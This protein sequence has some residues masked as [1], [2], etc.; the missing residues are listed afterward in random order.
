MTRA[1]LRKELATLWASPVPWVAGAVLQAVLALLFV[2]QLQG[3]SQAVVQPLFPIAGLLVVVT[4]PVLAMRTFAE[5]KRTGNLDVLLAMPVSAVPLAVGKWAGAWLTA[6]AIL[7]PSIV[8]A[9]LTALWGSPDPGPIVSG[10]VGVALLAAAVAAIGVLASAAT[11]SQALAALVTILTG[12]VLWFVGS[13][14]GGSTTTRVL[15]SVSLSERLRTF[16]SGGIDSGDL[17]FFIG[18]AMVCTL[19][20]AFVIRPRPVVGGV[21][22]AALLVTV[23]GAGTHQLTDLTEQKSLTLSGI[24]RDVVSAV[25]DDVTIT[26]F[27]G[28]E[29]AG[30]VETVTLL[31]RYARLSQH[32]DT[33]VVDPSDKPGDVRRFGINPVLGGVV[34]QRADAVELAAGPTEQDITSALARLVRGRDVNV[35]ITTGHGEPALATRLFEIAG[36][37]VQSIDLLATPSIPATCAMVL[38]AGPQQPLGA[39]GDALAKWIDADGKALV[40]ADPAADVDLSALLEPMGLGLER[41]VVFEGEASSVVNGDEAS[42]IVHSYSSAHPVVRGLP[43]TYFPGVQEV[44]VDELLHVP[45]LTVSR[46]AD[47]SSLSYL[48]TEPL[49]PSFDPALDTGG[50][51]TIAAAA[52]RSRVASEAKVARVRVVVVGDVDFATSSFVNEAANGRFLLQAVGW[53]TLDDELI[54]LSSNLPKNRPLDLTDARVA[55]ARALGILMIPGLFLLGGGL[56]WAVRRRR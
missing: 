29:D 42:P 49:V 54:P 47:T 15:G 55:Y 23:V 17:V 16:A 25:H 6:L 3:R 14:T 40:L 36:Y 18:V 48:E 52:D 41:G 9:G 10:F 56:V 39:G 12:L 38:V 24:T 35:C 44:T 2:D 26:A 31:D 21:A 7:L 22:I 8:L 5:E 53:L 51:I 28:R 43:P 27:I 20:A 45:G 34:V 46:L 11:S 4:V 33:D 32:L 50:P 19:A 37:T 1:I 13:A 30:R